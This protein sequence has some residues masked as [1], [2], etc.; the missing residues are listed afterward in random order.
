MSLDKRTLRIALKYGLLGSLLL[1]LLATLATEFLS[2]DRFGK[3]IRQ[4]LEQALHRKVEIGRVRFSLFYGPGFTLN[5]VLI[6]E[7]P[8]HGSAPF[9]YVDSLTARVSLPSLLAGRLE[10]SNLRLVDP[11]LNLVKL[12]DGPWSVQALLAAELDRPRGPASGAATPSLPE[13]Q[14]RNARVDFQLGTLKSVYYLT[15]ADIDIW[16]Q[17]GTLMTRF[18]GSPG[19]TDRPAQGFGRLIGSGRWLRPQGRDAQV[20]FDLQ[21]DRSNIS[22]VMTLLEGR[23]VGLHGEVASQARLSGPV[24][25]IRVDGRLQLFEV[26][27]WDLLP[28]KGE[29]WPLDYHGSIDLRGQRATLESGDSGGK[30]LPFTVR[31]EAANYLTRPEWRITATARDFPAAALIDV[32]RHFGVPL[33]A[34][35]S[36]DGKLNGQL[37]YSNTAPAEGRLALTEASLQVPGTAPMRVAKAEISVAA[38]EVR[39]DPARL[40]LG[41]NETATV[42]G[43]F[44]YPEGGAEVK[45]STPSLRI[46]DLKTGAGELLA[47]GRL[48]LLEHCTEGSWKGHLRFQSPGNGEGEWT[49]SFE[50]RDARIPVSG[51]AGPLHLDSAS[52]SMRGERLS[53]TRLK[54]RAGQMP[55]E[56]EYRH[57]PSYL[58]P[59][60]FRLHLAEASAAQLEQLLRP[61][62]DR[63]QGFLSRTLRIGRAPVPDWL[64]TRRAAGALEIASLHVGR[65]EFRDLHADVIWD[66]V[67]IQLLGL[68]AEVNGAAASGTLLTDLAGHLPVYQC[69]LRIEDLDSRL[70][71]VTAQADLETSG[72]GEESLLAHL[73]AGRLELVIDGTKYEG[74]AAIGKDGRLRA[75][76]SDGAKPLVLTGPLSPLQLEPAKP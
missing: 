52:V 34:R 65:T 26:H 19:R 59:H 64:R 62:L 12:P 51:I 53:L 1:L 63:S 17:N 29:A 55:F 66:G 49:G 69:A 41:E 13:I 38:G 16:E 20:E 24:S 37:A 4:A 30:P 9:A 71:Q 45:I 70:G 6:S 57:E 58:R 11:T 25:N 68:E 48:P 15:D 2:A 7:A 47:A 3:Q 67:R 39:L 31:V 44:H 60:R 72:L 32:V 75:D 14:V 22:D 10:F 33:P 46:S 21:L 5:D 36:A 61:S 56:G 23:D 28:P 50:L 27:R 40:E 54:G 42:E 18:T 74:H 35:A 76:L 43:V 8:S 73:K